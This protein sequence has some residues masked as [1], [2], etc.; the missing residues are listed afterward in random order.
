MPNFPSTVKIHI[1]ITHTKK[2]DTLTSAICQRLVNHATGMVLNFAFTKGESL[3]EAS[4]MFH[5]AKLQ[6]PDL[7]MIVTG[8]TSASCKIG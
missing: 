2:V 7:E 5:R 6:C 3:Q 1:D 4:T 8:T